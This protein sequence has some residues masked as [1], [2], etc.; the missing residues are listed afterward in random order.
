MGLQDETVR[1]VIDRCEELPSSLAGIAAM[2]AALRVRRILRPGDRGLVFCSPLDAARWSLLH[3]LRWRV[4]QC[5]AGS[6]PVSRW[7][8]CSP[9]KSA[10][11]G[12]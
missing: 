10:P 1:A 7:V 11:D 8:A 2:A 9:P 5:P 4:L 6:D 12:A 3:V